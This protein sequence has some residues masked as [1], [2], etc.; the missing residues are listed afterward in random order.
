MS[1]ERHHIQEE[2]VGAYLLSALTENEERA[3]EKHLAGVPDL[4]GRA[5][6]AASRRGRAAPLGGARRAAR[7]A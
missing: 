5:G 4:P 6:S 2:N 3:F 1:V 7:R